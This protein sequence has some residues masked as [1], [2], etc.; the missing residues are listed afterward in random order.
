VAKSYMRK[1]TDMDTNNV[2]YDVL[3]GKRACFIGDS[4]FGGHSLGRDGTWIAMLAEKYGMEHVNLGTNGCTLSACEGGANP[5]IKRYTDIP[6]TPC[7][8][9]VIEGGR[10]D[11][12]K[13][14]EIGEVGG[15]IATYKGALSALIE[16]LREKH[17]E[18]I[19]VAV[20]FWKVGNRANAKGMSCNE[21]TRAMMDV[22]SEMGVECIDTTNAEESLIDMTVSELRAQFCLVPGDVCHLNRMG[23]KRVLP[24]FERKLA[25]ILAKAGK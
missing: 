22:C 17:P 18:A 16:G 25:E 4:L 10:N 6:D 24:F 21:Y 2:Y 23:M 9:I 13:C 12:N 15:D 11:Y 20:T 1:R 7:D 5:I 19:L 8:L 14:A 3:H